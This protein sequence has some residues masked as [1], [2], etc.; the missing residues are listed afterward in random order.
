LHKFWAIIALYCTVV[1]TEARAFNSNEY[2]VRWYLIGERQM[3]NNSSSE[4]A[5]SRDE[6][7]VA[8]N[9]ANQLDSAGQ[10]ILNLL[11]KAAGA[12]EANSRRALETAQKLSSQLRVAEDRIAELEAEVQHFREKAERAEDW[13]RKIYREIEER[14]ITGPEEKRRHMSRRG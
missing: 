9:N 13:L 14:L 3:A 12:A 10:A 7:S 6:D 1:A 5:I 2:R 11:H 4:F 8:S